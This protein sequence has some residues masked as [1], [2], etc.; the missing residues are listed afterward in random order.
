MSSKMKMTIIFIDKAD[1]I[2]FN[3]PY[4]VY[5]ETTICYLFLEKHPQFL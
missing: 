5:K 1:D 4:K 3:I 2:V